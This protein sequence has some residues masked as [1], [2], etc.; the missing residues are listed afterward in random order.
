MSFGNKLS[1]ANLYLCSAAANNRRPS[2]STV[3][4]AISPMVRK[5]RLFMESPSLNL[6]GELGFYFL[7]FA[8]RRSEHNERT[9]QEQTGDDCADDDIRP[10]GLKQSDTGRGQ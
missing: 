6:G 5:F 8:K 2:I 4:A 10:T 3:A 1:G 9:P 7:Q